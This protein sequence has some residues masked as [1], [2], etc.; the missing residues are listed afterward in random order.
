MCGCCQWPTLRCRGELLGIRTVGWKRGL[1]QGDNEGMG[2]KSKR[3]GT[4]WVGTNG[5]L[6]DG[7]TLLAAP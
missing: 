1:A 7:L 3:Q 4:N 6:I 5:W 2:V